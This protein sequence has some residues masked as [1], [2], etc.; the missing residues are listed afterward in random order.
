MAL[1]ASPAALLFIVCIA[2]PLMSHA[3]PLDEFVA[4]DD[5]HFNWSYTGVKLAGSGG[6]DGYVYNMTS[7]MWLSFADVNRPVWWHWLVIIIPHNL[8]RSVSHK[9][10]LYI[11][12]E[13]NDHPESVPTRDSGHLF[14][15]TNL[16]VAAGTPAAVLFQV[17]NQPLWFPCNPYHEMLGSDQAIALTWWHFIRNTSAPQWVLELP[18]TKA[19]V[20]ALDA[21]E[22]IVP[23]YTN[24]PCTEFAV[25]GESKRGWTAWLVAAADPKPG[26]VIAVIPIVLD[27]L[28]LV[29]FAHRQW[30]FYGAW[31]F[32][33][34]PYVQ[35]NF[36][37]DL[38]LPATQK[39]MEIIDPYF[40]RERLTMPKFAINAVGD[41]F[42]M[43]D[44]QRYWAHNMSGEMNVLMLK[45]AEH[46]LFTGVRELQDAVA[47]FWQAVSQGY[48]R[49]NYTWF[50]EKNTGEITV[51]TNIVPKMVSVSFSWSGEGV[52]RGKRDFRWAAIN[53]TPCWE[54]V[55]QS[56]ACLRPLL[57]FTTN[58]T[59]INETAYSARL[60][61]PSEGWLGFFIEVF[62][63][64]PFGPDFH[65]TSPT[66][67]IPDTFPFPDC[68]GEACRGTLV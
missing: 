35:F 6:W 55:S 59:K 65:F 28:N 24:M 2:L 39:L 27:A 42:Q 58:A 13:G 64:N 68:H 4:V 11:S 49:P 40:Y 20:R 36:T 8:N 32:A 15:A 10:V 34:R 67:V 1:L 41:E 19:A 48:A 56:G 54:K 7:Q 23:L 21:M 16:S 25:T 52:S 12:S 17:P 60:D 53:A 18:M 62:W 51:T 45:N 63:A 22:M 38:D 33:F 44:D 50:I 3:T 61:Y 29:Q 9:A 31:T 14:V 46:D 43:V 30:Q 57:W 66:S 26:R 47:A 5:G 37:A